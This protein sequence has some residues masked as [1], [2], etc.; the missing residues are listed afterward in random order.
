MRKSEEKVCMI[1]IFE[2]AVCIAVGRCVE[3]CA[4]LRCQDSL[5]YFTMHDNVLRIMSQ[6]LHISWFNYPEMK[7]GL[8]FSLTRVVGLFSAQPKHVHFTPQTHCWLL[9]M[10]RKV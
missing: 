1:F 2:V 5:I 8:E 3:R 10:W 7:D 6:L 9:R 4:L